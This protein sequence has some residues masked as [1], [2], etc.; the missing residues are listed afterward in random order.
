M[1]LMRT[2]VTADRRLL[3]SAVG[4]KKQDEIKAFLRRIVKQGLASESLQDWNRFYMFIARAH[5]RRKRWDHHDVEGML[6]QYGVPKGQAKMFS[7][8]YWHGRCVL[9]NVHHFDELRPQYA[10]WASGHGAP[11]T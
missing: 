9:Y 8:V 5:A 2:V 4:S 10:G 7:E 11:L 6:V 1:E 3:S